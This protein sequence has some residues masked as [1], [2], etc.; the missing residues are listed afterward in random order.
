[1]KILSVERGNCS[2]DVYEHGHPSNDGYHILWGS[3]SRKNFLL[4]DLNRWRS[5]KHRSSSCTDCRWYHLASGIAQW[6]L[7]FPVPGQI[8]MSLVLKQEFDPSD[9][10]SVQGARDSIMAWFHNWRICQPMLWEQEWLW[11]READAHTLWVQEAQLCHYFI[12][13][14]VMSYCWSISCI[15]YC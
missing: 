9:A 3:A 12:S 4:H 14:S 6:M 10:I 11:E 13:Y 5:N 1:M 15:S 2:E 8:V 7:K